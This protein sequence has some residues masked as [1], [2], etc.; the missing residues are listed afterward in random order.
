MCTVLCL[1]ASVEFAGSQRFVLPYYSNS[2]RNGGRYNHNHKINWN[3]I[4]F[5]HALKNTGRSGYEANSNHPLFKISTATSVKSTQNLQQRTLQDRTQYNRRLYKGHW[6]TTSPQRTK[7][8][9]LYCLQCV[10]R[11]LLFGGFTVSHYQKVATD[12]ETVG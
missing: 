11:T 7:Q 9:N 1:V 12:P 5:L 10:S 6:R 2:Y 8:V 4:F 3:E